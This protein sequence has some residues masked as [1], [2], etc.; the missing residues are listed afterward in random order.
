VVTRLPKSWT[1]IVVTGVADEHM[2]AGIKSGSDF[3]TTFS[4]PT[5]LRLLA[6]PAAGM[7]S[8]SCAEQH[9]LAHVDTLDCP[10]CFEKQV[11]EYDALR[12]HFKRVHFRWGPA[13]CVCGTRFEFK[14]KS[15]ADHVMT[16]H[17]NLSWM[18]ATCDER[19][20]SAA[21]A[22]AHCGAER[23][24]RNASSSPLLCPLCL[25]A[26]VTVG[27]RERHNVTCK[28]KFAV[29]LR[30]GSAL[31]V[32]IR[33]ALSTMPGMAL[34]GAQVMPG[35]AR[36]TYLEDLVSRWE[37]LP[38]VVDVFEA[39]F[40][41]RAAWKGIS[42]L[43]R[44][45]WLELVLLV[46]L[47]HAGSVKW[48]TFAR[49]DA[50]A[51]EAFLEFLGS[52][53]LSQKKITV[54]FNSI[55]KEQRLEE[56]VAAF[57]EINHV[58][59]DWVEKGLVARSRTIAYA[60]PL[61]LYRSKLFSDKQRALFL[62]MFMQGLSTATFVALFALAYCSHTAMPLLDADGKELGGRIVFTASAALAAI[63]RLFASGTAGV[64]LGRV[65]L[66][67][68]LFSSI[69]APAKL[70]KCSAADVAAMQ[71]WVSVADDMDDW[72]GVLVPTKLSL[73]SA[74]DQKALV[75]QKA[76]A[77]ELEADVY[78]RYCTCNSV[79]GRNE[80]ENEL[81]AC[82]AAGGCAGRRWFH[83]ECGHEPDEN[84]VFLCT[85]CLER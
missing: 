84:G 14:A 31:I 65:E 41:N 12:N 9:A 29:A 35:V 39:G 53:A 85:K 40:G 55:T 8:I 50:A 66:F 60:V 56:N 25:R 26:Y 19:C 81:V 46:V 10:F 1:P 15:F 80:D 13:D 72:R 57:A 58:A 48:T 36:D 69:V 59:R 27:G 52:K 30:Q 18:C 47:W 42:P 64:S 33:S 28:Q 5:G 21:A 63:D 16:V 79:L 82:E 68:G 7:L 75:D 38:P 54:F 11:A 2:R 34:F 6:P 43:H 62:P 61:A 3:K 51:A 22:D 73:L 78:P 44:K 76:L 4:R 49:G 37:A 77:A 32:G 23:L 24:F 20:D 83:R 70:I 45:S 67:F 17:M 71:R 74:N